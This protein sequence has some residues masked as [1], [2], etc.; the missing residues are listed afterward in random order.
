MIDPALR[1][2]LLIN[3]EHVFSEFRDLNVGEFPGNLLGR[4]QEGK[5]FKITNDIELLV[6][7]PLPCGRFARD[8]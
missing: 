2:A 4:A 5:K 8:A 6:G 7:V 3:A 1:H